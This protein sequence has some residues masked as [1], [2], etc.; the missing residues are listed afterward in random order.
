MKNL[1]KKTVTGVMIASMT[2]SM[3]TSC[4]KGSG[5]QISSDQNTT[6][7]SQTV[8]VFSEETVWY[9]TS[10]SIIDSGNDLESNL[11]L[12]GCAQGKFIFY[13]LGSSVYELK[14]YDQEGNLTSTVDISNAYKDL[15]DNVQTWPSIIGDKLYLH[16]MAYNGDWESSREYYLGNVD[17]ETGALGDPVQ[18]KNYRQESDSI[19]GTLI[20]Y[21]ESAGAGNYLIEA[22]SPDMG[23]APGVVFLLTDAEGNLTKIDATSCVNTIVYQDDGY[24]DLGDG[25]ILA[26]LLDGDGKVYVEIDT[27]NMTASV[28]SQDYSW[29]DNYDVYN[30]DGYGL[31]A[32]GKYSISSVDLSTGSLTEIMYYSQSNANKAVLSDMKPY[33]ISDGSI[34]LAG[35]TRVPAVNPYMGD[36]PQFYIIHLDKAESNPNVGKSEIKIASLNGSFDFVMC[37]A[38]SKFNES[39]SQYF[40]TYDSRYDLSNFGYQEYNFNSNTTYEEYEVASNNASAELT[41]Q[42]TMDIMTGNGPDIIMNGND[43]SALNNPEYL[44]DLSDYIQNNVSE[45]DYFRNVIDTYSNNGTVC[46][47]PLSFD[48]SGICAQAGSFAADQEGFTFEQYAEFVNGPCNGFD[49]NGSFDR[50]SLCKSLIDSSSDQMMSGT[51]VNFD[52]AAFRAIAEYTK[53]IAAQVTDGSSDTDNISAYVDANASVNVVVYIS[54]AYYYNQY[55][56]DDARILG[57]PSVDGRGPEARVCETVGISAQSANIDG[58]KEFVSYLI[59]DECQYMFGCYHFPVKKSA[60]TLNAQDIIAQTNENIQATIDN[61][62]MPMIYD[63]PLVII[64][65]AS[66]IDGMT[67]LIERTHSQVP[68]DPAISIIVREDIQAYYADQ[69]S[70]D[71]IIGI[72]ND[73]ANTVVSE[74]G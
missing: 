34:L 33:M 17:L 42:L 22:Y 14:I 41:T 65:E 48:I 5:D 2:L 38:V 69:K 66:L 30:V 74:R 37:E 44:L 39:S 9:N 72:I 18:I 27:N 50:L 28:P 10:S 51:D 53:N 56:Q 12:V 58:C 68:L 71:E 36:M 29:L 49:P 73:R 59:G 31:V 4:G 64:D 21:D 63:Y 24:I 47:L 52:N 13:N 43:V 25:K 3:I 40:I 19:S 54:N 67:N 11:S 8:D 61:P 6:G 60:F 16:M 26:C 45:T 62:D 15:D 7:E 20:T 70:L 1:V 46:Q 35:E 32:M 23:N 57:F 55:T